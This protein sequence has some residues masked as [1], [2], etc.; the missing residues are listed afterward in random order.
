[1][2]REL[3]KM[4]NIA[5]HDVEQV[6]E[7]VWLDTYQGISLNS[8]ALSIMTDFK[9]QKPLIIDADTLASEAEKMMLKAHVRLKIV[10]NQDNKLIGV[11]SLENLNSQEMMKKVNGGSERLDLLVSDFMLPKKDLK[12]INFSELENATVG[13]IVEVLKS[14]GLQHCLVVD[15]VAH[16]IRGIVSASDLARGLSIPMNLTVNPTF[17]DVFN[18]VHG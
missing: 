4:K 5:L 11:V 12:V 15:R 13:D 16:Q 6:D 17:L 10:V 7:L 18:A 1:M 2:E 9:K 14:N 3:P 8:P